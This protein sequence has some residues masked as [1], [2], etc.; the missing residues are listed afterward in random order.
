MRDVHQNAGGNRSLCESCFYHD[1]NKLC[2]C[3]RSWMFLNMRFSSDGRDVLK[4][5]GYRDLE[6]EV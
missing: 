1:L 6:A 3:R 2:E 4:C 5:D